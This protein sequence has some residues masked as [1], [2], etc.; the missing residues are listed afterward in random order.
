MSINPIKILVSKQPSWQTFWR[1]TPAY[2]IASVTA[3]LVILVAELAYIAGPIEPVATAML[4]CLGATIGALQ[5][6]AWK[7]IYASLAKLPRSVQLAFWWL[8][9]LGVGAQ[10]AYAVG[11]FTRLHG[12]YRN[13]ALQVFMGASVAVVGLGLVT[14]C[15]QPT[16]KHLSGLVFDWRSPLRLS[17]GVLLLLVALLSFYIDNTYYVGNYRAAHV[18]LRWT[19]WL[20]AMFAT[21][22]LL[23]RLP[24]PGI[25]TSHGLVLLI[26]LVTL[27]VVLGRLQPEVIATLTM[28]P[29]SASILRVSRSIFDFDRDG[30]DNLFSRDCN[31]FDP[32]INPAAR[33][34]PENGIDDN[35]LFGDAKKRAA[36]AEPP[37]IPSRPSPFD[38]VLITVDSVRPDHLGLYNPAYGREGRNTTPYLDA[39]SRKAVV[40][41]RAYTAGAWTSISIAAMMRGIYPRRLQWTKYY[42]TSRFRFLRKSALRT[43]TRREKVRQMFPLAY[44]DPNPTL[45]TLLRR[46]GMVAVAVV[47]DGFTQV[48][49]R[50]V[51]IE[52]QY[53]EFLEVERLLNPHQHNDRGNVMLANDVLKRIP[54]DQRLFLWVHFFGP[55]A[56][57]EKHRSVRRYGPTLKD[58]YDHEIRFLDWQ[59]SRLLKQI[60]ERGA[61][62][63]IAIA[64]DHGEVFNDPV[65]VHGLAV[66]EEDI[67]VPLIMRVPGWKPCRVS[68]IVS[69]V[70]IVPTLLALTGTP[71]P[72]GID[73]VDLTPWTRD[74]RLRK[75][76]MLISDT[77][78]YRRSD[79]PTLD[80]IAGFDGKRKVV[81]NLVDH[82]FTA[83]DQSVL[84]G[85]PE[86]L[87]HPTRDP[88]ARFVLQY[89]EETG[90]PLQPRD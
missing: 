24:I 57:N 76:R 7:L 77:W 29:W 87:Y 11:A 10:I 62:T 51:G 25:K 39:W 37:P 89:V 38:V 1:A 53:D 22:V 14:S 6:V 36:N 44:E 19:T 73:G 34:I 17:F 71:A 16:A 32:R 49:S 55:H 50:G 52:K 5:G 13:L 82:A 86:A 58:G 54:T 56:G 59:L 66:S 43:M 65:R 61:P 15:F 26:G 85:I 60:E 46:R 23:R 35:C 8:F 83:Y 63:V 27:I 81:L 2:P 28:R 68:Q 67:R 33:E 75:E 72:T 30:Y 48:L 40:F 74:K 84:K 80:L 12:P 88:L 41:E 90:G 20:S 42:E 78:R 47:Y 21:V 18:G 4:I 3:L 31:D 70:D 69:L 9:S 45:A 79:K 64:S